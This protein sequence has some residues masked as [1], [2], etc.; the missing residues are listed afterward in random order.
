VPSNVRNRLVYSRVDLF[1]R[2]ALSFNVRSRLSADTSKLFARL[3]AG[4]VVRRDAH[5]QNRNHHPLI[6]PKLLPKAG[7]YPAPGGTFNFIHATN[8]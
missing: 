4:L 7:F 3:T 1:G 8:E 5:V 2:Y 6:L